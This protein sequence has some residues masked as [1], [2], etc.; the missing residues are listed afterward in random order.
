MKYNEDQVNQYDKIFRENMEIALP[1]IIR[2]LLGIDIVSSEEIPDDIQ[3]TKERKPD[4]LKKITDRDGSVFILHIE[5]QAKDEKQM[6]YRMAEYHIMLMRKY[7]LS[8]EQFVLY[9]GK[10]KSKMVTEIKEKRLSF[11]YR[12]I[13]LSQVDYKVFLSSEK[14]EEK[15]LAILADFREESDETALKNILK[16]VQESSKGD[17]SESRYFKQLRILAQIRNLDIKFMEAMESITKYFKEERDP[18][19]RRGEAKGKAE[20]KA[21]EA[22]A[23]AIEMK[24]DGMPISQIAKFTKLS[25][26]EIEKL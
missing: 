9:M 22:K 10:G 6:I 17:F 18:L 26:A 14:P 11:N 12:I 3:H 4:L 24:K 1:G 23:I 13:E 20:G 16:D 8:I 15:I 19:Y 5:Y 7:G 25:E 21:A 2:N